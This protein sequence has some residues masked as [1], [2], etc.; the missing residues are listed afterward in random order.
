MVESVRL[1]QQDEEGVVRRWRDF[2][3]AAT[4]AELPAHG[5]RMVKSLGDGMLI[6][7]DSAAAAVRCGLAMQA[8]IAASEACIAPS[9]QIRLRM[10][11]HIADVIV[12]D[13]DLFGEG[14]NL[15]ARLAGLAGPGEIVVSAETRDGLTAVLD[16]DIEDLGE[17]YL[18]HMQQPVRAYRVGPPGQWPVLE[19]GS[20][21]MPAL[22][23]TIAVIPFAARSADRQYDVLGE[24]LAD[25]VIS[26]LSRTPYLN[27]ISR[28]S[29]TVFRGRDATLGEIGSL[30][31]ADYV[32][33]GTFRVAG[34][35]LIV[36]AE[37]AETKSGRVAWGSS[38]KGSVTGVV[39]GEDPLI[40][41]VVAAVSS[42][43]VARELER[44]Q[45]LALPTLESY[46]LLIGAV[47]LMH[48]LSARSFERARHMLQ[49]LEE[50]APRHPIPHAWLAKWHVLR[51]QQGWSTDPKLEAQ[52]A[53]DY[54]RCALDIDGHCSLALT[55]DGF[56]HVNLLKRLDLAQ[57][58]YELA[59]RVN[60]N[61]S[62]A[63][64]LKGTLHAFKGEGSSAMEGTEQALRL[65]P[66]DPLRYFYESLA[67]TAALSAGQ[68]DHAIELAQ[69]SLRANRTHTSTLRALAISQVLLGRLDDARVTVRDL[70]TLEPKLTVKGYLERSPSSTFETGRIWST[71]LRDAGVPEG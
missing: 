56:V 66:L 34:K 49:A 33:S 9:H 28:L 39:S 44:A 37:L 20:S 61:E 13:I 59:L 3:D 69:R 68:Y 67:A 4:H 24:V 12:D 29:T 62:L 55:I 52:R 58:R 57:E 25:E 40:D 53:L 7:L 41:A 32:L 63:W 54:T 35:Q 17:C 31:K 18:K 26:A 22:Q 70:L 38:L 51:V 36:V 65:S 45:S 42:A 47:G 60:P 46:T 21:A 19:P 2:L 1:I 71:A 23:P 48:R 43:V 8:R 30:L 50:R 10:G 5:G 11:V 64:L 15:A 16:A 14:V 6:E 27:V